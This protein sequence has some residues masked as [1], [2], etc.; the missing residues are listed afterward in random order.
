MLFATTPMGIFLAT[1]Y[2]TMPQ[3]GMLMLLV[4]LPLVT[5]SG[6]FTPRE[7][8]PEIVKKSC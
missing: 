2:R 1:I 5:L 8:M 4:L 3:F 6:A 7:S